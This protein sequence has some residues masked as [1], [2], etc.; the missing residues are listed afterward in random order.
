[1]NITRPALAIALAVSIVAVGQAEAAKKPPKKVV[2]PVCMLVTDPAGDANAINLGSPVPTTNAGSSVD[3]LDI[4]SVDIASDKKLLTTVMRVKK[5]ASTVSTA[6]MGLNWTVSFKVDTQSFSI[7]AH[8]D[9]TGKITYDASYAST[10]GGSLYP[11]NMAGTFDT[12]KS[13]IHITVPI[14]LMAKQ[15]TIKLGTKITAIA[16]ATFSEVLIPEATGAL[17]GGTFFSTTVNEYDWTS[18]GK[19]YISGTPSCVTPGV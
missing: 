16:G 12:N 4:T 8:A 13:E 17:G 7:A 14:D 18:P 6:P 1:M 5:L 10:T 2:K 3:A 15:A 11:G 9:P 19:D